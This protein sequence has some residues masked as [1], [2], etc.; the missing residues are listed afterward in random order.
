MSSKGD[1]KRAM[2]EEGAMGTMPLGLRYLNP[3]DHSLSLMIVVPLLSL[4]QLTLK[5]S[6]LL[7]IT[8]NSHLLRLTLD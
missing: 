7:R 1:E 2:K 5:R 4:P 3:C 6:F 8:A